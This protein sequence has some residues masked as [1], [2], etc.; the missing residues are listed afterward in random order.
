MFSGAGVRCRPSAV[1][2]S[3]GSL[4]LWREPGYSPWPRRA[5]FHDRRNSSS[6][7]KNPGNSVA[8]RNE[9]RSV[10]IDRLHVDYARKI[11]PSGAPATWS[12]SETSSPPRGNQAFRFRHRQTHP[13][14]V[15]LECH[16][17]WRSSASRLRCRS[18]APENCAGFFKLP[19]AGDG[20]PIQT[21]DAS[22][23]NS[24][25]SSSS[26]FSEP[27]PMK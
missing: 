9:W 13:T 14:R 2:I 25:C 6:F 15:T 8:P 18:R 17:L 1:L 20:I 3:S 21:G 7:S 22:F 24:A 27:A 12:G 26:T 10:R 19:L 11:A 16:D 5:I 4:L 23:G